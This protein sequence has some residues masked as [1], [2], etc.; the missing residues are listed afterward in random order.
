MTSPSR[1]ARELQR[2]RALRYL[3]DIKRIRRTTSAPLAFR[4]LWRFGVDLAPPHFNRF[5]VNATFFGG[6]FGVFWWIIMWPLVWLRDGTPL[7]TT[8]LAALG[9]AA[10]F[11]LSMAAYY[12]HDARKR[13][14]PP[15]DQL[16]LAE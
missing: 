8:L 5:L 10:F 3:Y 2:E 1:A 12:R 15:M 16:P 6:F 9:V 11:G 4:L 13:G 14:V 7:A